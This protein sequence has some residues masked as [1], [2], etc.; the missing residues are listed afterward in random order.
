MNK[1]DIDCYCFWSNYWHL[2]PVYPEKRYADEEYI[3]RIPRLI[4]YKLIQKLK[5]EFSSS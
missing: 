5:I 4:I 3:E 2:L 1:T